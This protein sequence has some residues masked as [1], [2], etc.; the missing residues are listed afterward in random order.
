MREADG[1]EER[2]HPPLALLPGE[3][4]EGSVLAAW[5]RELPG[6]LGLECL[7][8]VQAG[9]SAVGIWD[10]DELIRHKVIKKYVVRGKGRAQTLHLKTRGKS[11]YGSR[12]RLQN[13]R[14]QLEET[15]Q[16]LQD[17]WDELGE[18][19]RIV[20]SCPVRTWPEL[21]KAEPPPPFEK[22]DPRLRRA[23]LDVRIPSFEELLRVRSLLYRGRRVTRRSN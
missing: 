6:N 18:P 7:L 14:A 2:L 12:L 20:A 3:D 1:L 16:K 21:F 23:G 10:D 17:W 13:A 4:L 11:R 9:A 8:L 22:N 19:E 15:N 5:L